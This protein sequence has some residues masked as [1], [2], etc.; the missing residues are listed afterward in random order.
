MRSH[1]QRRGQALCRGEPVTKGYLV[2]GNILVLKLYQ[3]AETVVVVQSSGGRTRKLLEKFI[4]IKFV[5]V[6][7]VKDGK[8]SR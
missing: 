5:E 4:Q 6:D 1:K 2:E 7:K 3:Q 8:L